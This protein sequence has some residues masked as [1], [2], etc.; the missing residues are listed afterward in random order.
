MS[1]DPIEAARLAADQL[2]RDQLVRDQFVRDQSGHDQKARDQATQNQVC[3]GGCGKP[4]LGGI[5]CANCIDQERNHHSSQAPPQVD[6]GPTVEGAQRTSERAGGGVQAQG[7]GLGNIILST[8][9]HHIFPLQWAPYF[10]EKVPEL[11]IDD[12]TMTIP[13]EK[14]RQIHRWWNVE[15]KLWMLEHE[16]PTLADVENKAVELLEKAGIQEEWMHSFHMPS[17]C[18]AR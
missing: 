1:Y 5:K 12:W 9:H 10:K 18:G 17:T 8:H 2:V 6:G 14:H 3:P 4:S 7:V 15:W 13:V 11:D 16:H